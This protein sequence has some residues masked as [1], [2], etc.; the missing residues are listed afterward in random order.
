KKEAKSVKELMVRPYVPRFLREGDRADLKVVVNN[1]SGKPMAGRVTIDILDPDTNASALAAFG[2]SADKAS[3]PFSV[4]A[5]RGATVTLS[6]S[7]PRRVGLYA[8]KVTAA[9]G[10]L[11]DG[12][13]R[14]VPVLPGRLH[15]MQSRFAALHDRD[16]RE[17]T[18]ADLARNDDAT[19]VNEQMVVTVDAQLFDSL[20]QALP[21]LV[22]YPY[23]CTEQ[24][25]NRFVSTGIV[26]SLFRDYPAIAKMAE[27]M[28]RRD[29][30]LE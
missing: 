15:L 19:L 21:Y 23:E 16:R 17:L 1:A 22:N 28:S 13:L 25:L 5:G 11:S 2:V 8:F 20:L 30:R 7:A 4:E 3:L 9:A 12:E 26:S 10:D 6:L 14:P 24:T 27:E 18:F 29:T